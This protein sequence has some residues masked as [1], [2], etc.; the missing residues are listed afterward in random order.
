MY[1]DRPKYEMQYAVL[2]SDGHIVWGEDY[3]WDGVGENTALAAAISE[4]MNSYYDEHG[5]I[6][7]WGST[8]LKRQVGTERVQVGTTHH[9]AVTET[10]TRC[11]VCGATR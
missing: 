10:V 5:V 11:T 1:E 2:F 9:P 6:L 8:R 4:Y 3:P 7:S